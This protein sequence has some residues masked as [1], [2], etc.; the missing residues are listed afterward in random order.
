[1]SYWIFLVC[2]FR[3]AMD[4]WIDSLWSESFKQHISSKS[5]HPCPWA[6]SKKSIAARSCK[7][8]CRRLFWSGNISSSISVVTW[9]CFLAH[10]TNFSKL[11]SV[12]V[13]ATPGT[14]LANAALAATPSS[15]TL[16]LQSGVSNAHLCLVISQNCDKLEGNIVSL[17]K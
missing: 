3:K 5:S 17:S 16:S 6:K 10:H 11:L 4:L 8:A 15:S 12:A 14:K 9:A 7:S 2:S 13:E 1:M